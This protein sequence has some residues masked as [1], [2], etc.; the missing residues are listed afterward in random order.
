MITRP[1]ALLALATL[2]AVAPAQGFPFETEADRRPSVKTGGNVFIRAGRILTASRGAIENGQILI[3]EGKIVAIGKNLT[4]PVGVTVLDLPDKVVAPGLVDT[5]SHRASDATN[6][7][8]DSITAEVRIGDVLNSTSKNLWTALASG[9]TSGLILHGSANAVGGQSTVIKFRYR[10]PVTELPIPDAPR[11][12]KFALGENVTRSQSGTATRFP[13]SR[14]GVE[15][16]YRRGFESARQYMASWDAWEKDKSKPQPRRDLRRETL[17]D[18]LR[19]KVWVQCHSYRADEMLMMARLSAEYGFKIGALQHG[20][21]AYKIAPDLAK[22][23]VG[24]GIF[25]DNWS[26]KVEGYDGIPFNAAICVRAGVLTSINTDSL[27]GTVALNVDAGKTMRFGG[28]TE[29]Q[30]LQLITLNPAKQLGIDHRTGSLDVGKDADLSIWDGNPLSVY[31]KCAMTLIDGEVF[32]QRKDAFGVDRVWAKPMTV[33]EVNRRPLPPLPRL[34]S[35]YA[36]TGG[37]VYPVSG[38]PIPGGTVVLVD[39]KITAV[40]RDVAIPRGAVRV[41]ARG[42]RVYP[43]FIDAGTS[44]GLAEISPVSETVDNRELGDYQPDMVANTAVQVQSEHIPVTRFTGI[45]NAITR[46]IGGVVAGQAALL[47]LFG[48]TT[49]QMGL[50][51]KAALMVNF[52]TAAG[53]PQFDIDQLCCGA[54]DLVRMFGGAVPP[55]IQEAIDAHEEIHHHA[56]D[57]EE[58]EALLTAFLQRQQQQTTGRVRDLELYFE[59]ALKYAQDRAASVTPRDLAMEALVPYAQGKAPVMLR[60]R[61]VASIRQAVAFAEKY[62]LKAILVGAADAWKE[63]ALLAKSKI[64]VILA[65]AGRSVL[66]ANAPVSDWDPYDTPYA[67]PYLLAKAG[68]KFCFMSDDNAGASNLPIRVAQSCGYGLTPESAIRAMTLDAAEILGV[69]DRLGS[70]Q[71][72]KLGNLFISDGDPME[73][74]SQVRYLFID[75]RPVPLE[76]RATRLRD[77][78]AARLTEAERALERR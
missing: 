6:E 70:L 5:H 42:M 13:R 71:P 67:T 7:G 17:A 41:N 63:T 44:L 58:E 75:G 50:V 66:F 25:M 57:E 72:G 9:Q 64:P 10:R 62:K 55:E 43:G 16:V 59:R 23:G 36:I 37:T 68:V 51:P 24:V 14:M 34:A 65:P 35:A 54:A 12:I 18:I 21:E 2:F 15:A 26:F 31:G 49:V 33:P 20:L 74:S 3:R 69:A 46:P 4:P 1:L 48:Y 8:S 11:Q 40:G 52:P 78:Y 60:V 77:Q 56:K 30:A 32:F 53:A 19:G 76:S 61:N 45:T 38:P 28:L 29:E 22:L 39:G 47:N 27:G 73:V